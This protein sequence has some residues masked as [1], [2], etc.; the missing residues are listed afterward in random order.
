MPAIRDWSFNY[1]SSATATTISCPLPAYE[2]NDL[3]LAVLSTDTGTTQAWSSTGW[4]QRFSQSNTPNLAVMWKIAGASESDP[5]FTYTIGETANAAILSIRDVDTTTPIANNAQGNITAARTAFPTTTA[6]RNNSLL[7]YGWNHGSTATVLPSA[8]E[9]PV[10]QITSKDG[11]AHND[12]I[13]WGFMPSSGTTPSNIILSLTGTTYNG[14]KAVVVINPPASGATVIPT[15]CAADS[16]VYIDPIHGITAYNGNTAWAAT[17]L[18][19]FTS[20]LA[21]RTLANA[22]VA[23]QTDR[24]INTY[25]SAGGMTGPATAAST[26]F[27]AT[28][29]LAVA[30]KPNV[31]GKNVLLHVMPLLPADLQTVDGVNLGRGIAVGMFSAAGNAKTWHVH[32][33]GTPW[34]IT[35]TPVVVNEG[36]TSGIIDTRGT[37]DQTSVLGFACF[38]SGFLVSSDWYW[39]MIWVLDTTT[40]AGGTAAEPINVTGVRIAASDG[41]ERMSVIQQAANQL[42]ILQPLQFGDGGT[43][44]TY[45]KLES[46]AIEFPEIYNKTTRQVY[47]CSVENVAGITYY[48]GASDT[49]IHR[50]SIISSASRYHWGLHASSS[51]SATYDF[52]GLSVIGAGTITLARAIT[53]T[54]LTINDYSTLDVSSLTLNSSTITN[55]PSVNDSITVNSTTAFNSCSINVTGVSSGNRL[56]STATPNKFT[57]CTLT[58]SGSTGHAMRLT[59]IG[60]FS[61]VGNTFTGFGANGT[62]SAA[63]FNDSGGAVTLNISGGGTTPTIRNGTGA[64]TTVNNTVTLEVNNPNSTFVGARVT[65][66]ANSGGPETEGTVLMLEEAINDGGIYRATQDYNFLGNQ[67]VTIRARLVGFQPFE[68][69]GTIESTGLKVTAIWQPDPIAYP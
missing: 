51:T 48:A 16:S 34:G 18:T 9:G 57:N 31:T 47:Y 66:Y 62:N 61:L 20:P 46:T 27:G 53:I 52:S 25:R 19:Y 17:A 15:Y 14:L 5:T 55:V 38:T 21:G 29:V 56:L 6:T 24:G 69:T 58:G 41:H 11:S 32:G 44:P 43:N 12:G 10:T 4:T 68:T 26:W 40:V 49:I 39:M 50:N 3:L 65:I 37:F 2:E 8:I 59:A 36:N 42:L 35:R 28:K 60:T 54:G 13:S 30:S 64:S 23:A 7:I 63:I 1:H 22:A 33:A 45:L 67:P